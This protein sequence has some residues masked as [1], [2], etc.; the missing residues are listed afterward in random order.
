[1]EKKDFMETIAKAGL[2]LIPVI[3]GSL[4]SITGDYF[5]ARKEVRL[6]SFIEQLSKDFE[7]KQSL[8]VKEYTCTE[9]FYDIYE[10]I[11]CDVLRN[12]TEIKRT[13]LKNLLVNSC[14]IPNTSYD[15]TEEF[16]HLI[17][18]LSPTNLLI[19]SVFYHCQHI[20]MNNEKEDIETIMTKIRHETHLESD[21]LILDYIG[22]LESRNL[23]EGFKN[24]MYSIDGGTV[25]HGSRSYITEKGLL[26]CS[27]VTE[28]DEISE[29][30]SHGS[31][32]IP[33]A[34]LKGE[35]VDAPNWV[36]F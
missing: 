26:F 12:R 18:V 24:N 27:Y 31:A 6:L 2:S 32:I 23:V 14:T 13:M 16:Q 8:F 10:N 35:K 1:M 17:D 9:E 33:K 30:S 20:P 11:L 5:S 4:A 3:G 19:L 36:E 21:S 28:S 22:E 34:E 15:R 25:L 7:K 29:Y